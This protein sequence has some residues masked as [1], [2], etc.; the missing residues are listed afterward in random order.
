M[1]TERVGRAKSWLEEF[2]PVGQFEG[3]ESQWQ[4]FVASE[5]PVATLFG[6]Y[7][8]G[9]S[10]ILR[11]LLVEQS[12]EVPEWVTISAR[13]E[14]FEVGTVEFRG[15]ALRDTPGVAPGAEDA[16]GVAN[17]GHA[18]AAVELTD[19]LVVVMNP[20][21][22]TAERD[23]MLGVLAGDWPAGSLVLVISRF[24]D[25]GV[26]PEYDLDGYHQLAERK[27]NE[28]RESL[29]LDPAI[30][31]FV[32]A[33]DFEQAAGGQRQPDVSTWDESRPWDGMTELSD[34]LAE[35]AGAE[36]PALRTAAES[37]FWVG[38][39]A[40]ALDQ[41][42]QDLQELETATQAARSL[43]SRRDTFLAEIDAQEKASRVSINGAVEEA[44]RST[45]RRQ[46]VDAA[47]I[48]T[49]VN[50][51]LDA[52]WSAQR[53]EVDRVLRDA[54][55]TIEVQRERPA[56]KSL[57][58]LY[59]PDQDA[60][61]ASARKVTSKVGGLAEKAKEAVRAV[62]K[63]RE[64]AKK[65]LKERAAEAAGAL[66]DDAVEAASNVP[67]VEVAIAALPVVMEL[68]GMVEDF[69]GDK[70]AAA[71]RKRRRT[72][73]QDQVTAIATRA[74]EETMR[75]W[76]PYLEE[77][78]AHLVEMMGSGAEDAGML[79]SLLAD[80]AALVSRGEAVLMQ[81]AQPS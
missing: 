42:H 56:W 39:V 18:L 40:A 2:Y 65:G 80:A 70:Q 45:M 14:T 13:H 78:R 51:T 35:L 43:R 1:T 19:V 17:T 47:A 48:E 52:W 55:A 38:S 30:P 76:A 72:E 16:R 62:D 69:V 74:G 3:L 4:R 20:Q 46:S 77:V 9:K 10:A 15:I 67:K 61:V 11:R 36:L 31:V 63:V 12:L 75:H 26:S 21:L 8:T 32:V 25:A 24:D 68:I 23:L 66:K 27:V 59:V 5:R 33:P 81:H 73:L 28:L 49:A 79:E 44:I 60:K 6:A 29:E 71:D 50:Q 57:A 37:R 7:D 64:E 22:P 34:A 41:A 54:R 58:D 53:V